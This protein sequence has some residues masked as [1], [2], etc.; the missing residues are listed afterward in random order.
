MSTFLK[1][2]M[3]NRK[4]CALVDFKDTRFVAKSSHFNRNLCFEG[5]SCA[6]YIATL[7]TMHNDNI[8][9]LPVKSVTTPLVIYFAYEVTE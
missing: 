7:L 6:F 8:P 4:Y 9:F 2:K 3:S 5:L 1:P